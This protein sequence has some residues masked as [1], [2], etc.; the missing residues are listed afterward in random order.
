LIVTGCFELRLA[1]KL[2]AGGRAFH[3]EVHLMVC[4]KVEAVFEAGENLMAGGR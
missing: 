1:A 2:L 4:E 3:D